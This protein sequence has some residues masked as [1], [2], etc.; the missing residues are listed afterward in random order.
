MYVL[1][2]CSKIQNLN[3]PFLFRRLNPSRYHSCFVDRNNL[4]LKK[5]HQFC[6]IKVFKIK[7][8]NNVKSNTQLNTFKHRILISKLMFSK[9]IDKKFCL[10]SFYKKKNSRAWKRR[11]RC[12]WLFRGRRPS[13]R[14]GCHRQPACP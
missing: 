5:N 14:P 3:S 10:S 9:W 8:S 7:I 13:A 6:L 4:K 12:C 1:Y 11:G 2:V